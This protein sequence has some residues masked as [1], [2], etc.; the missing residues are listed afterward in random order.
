MGIVRTEEDAD[1]IFKKSLFYRPLERE[2]PPR[3]LLPPR[4][5]EEPPRLLLPP[6]PREEPPRL[7]LPREERSRLLEDLRE[8]ELAEFRLDEA[9]S[10]FPKR[11]SSVL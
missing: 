3:L 4:P 8:R 5:R 10:P 9:L 2:E 1:F 7:L 11:R 6:Q